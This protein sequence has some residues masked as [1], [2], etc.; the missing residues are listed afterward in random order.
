MLKENK[1]NGMG[2]IISR[3]HYSTSIVYQ[4]ALGVRLMYIEFTYMGSTC[5]GLTPYV[6]WCRINVG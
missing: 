1:D 4:D 3:S 5:I 6:S 2:C